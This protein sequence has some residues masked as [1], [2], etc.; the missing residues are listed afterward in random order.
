MSFM[1]FGERL[2]IPT[3]DNEEYATTGRVTIDHDRCNGCGMCASI[4]PGKAIYISGGPKEREAYLEEE[5]P[6]CMSCNDCA[7]ICPRDAVTVSVTYDFGFFYKTLHR[8]KPALP[9][10]FGE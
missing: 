10:H 3:Y 1:T 2:R 4:C 7:A 8:G 6:Q 5:F 9:R